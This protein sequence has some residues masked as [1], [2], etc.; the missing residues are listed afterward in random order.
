MIIYAQEDNKLFVDI[1]SGFVIKPEDQEK[2]IKFVEYLLDSATFISRDED[3]FTKLYVLKRITNFDFNEVEP[4]NIDY[5]SW[6]PL[7]YK[8]LA[9]FCK[10]VDDSITVKI[11]SFEQLPEDMRKDIIE[12]YRLVF[13]TTFNEPRYLSY[14]I[15][16]K[17]VNPSKGSVTDKINTTVVNT[18]SDN[19]TFNNTTLNNTDQRTTSTSN[20][21]IDPTTTTANDTNNNFNL[22]DI[23][24]RNLRGNILLIFVFIILGSLLFLAVFILKNKSSIDSKK[25][26]EKS[27][28]SGDN[29]NTNIVISNIQKEIEFLKQRYE[30][31]ESKINQAFSRIDDISNKTDIMFS[32]YEEKLAK[33]EQNVDSTYNDR[34]EDSLNEKKLDRENLEM[35]MFKID[36]LVNKIKVLE[37][38]KEMDINVKSAKTIS[39]LHSF[40]SKVRET[41]SINFI[42]WDNII[43]NL[44][45]DLISNLDKYL[46]KYGYN[47]N[48]NKIRKD[49]ME[50]CEIE[51]IY[52][53][54]EQ[55]KVNIMDHRVEGYSRNHNL[56]TGV[57]TE[58]REE[59]YKYKGITV[60]RAKVIENRV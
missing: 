28:V 40:K 48:I 19:T 52:I 12:R 43:K 25:L 31:L 20:L 32:K 57:I 22:S 47:E 2:K 13:G 44:I 15:T 39:E 9:V 26:Y 46:K 41:K 7:T 18:I 6:G 59:G 35:I 24:A 17:N 60:K 55:T 54:P 5:Y 8:Y 30:L 1:N 51:E 10:G 33:N 49:I 3:V 58:V 23:F 38:Y 11:P 45:I 50:E 53:I 34:F 16:F 36:N 21:G 29:S 42:T 27:S 14:D 37:I 4:T 56:P